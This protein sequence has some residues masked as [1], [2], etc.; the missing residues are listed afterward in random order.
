M[1][2]SGYR[3]LLYWLLLLPLSLLA[4]SLQDR[5][6]LYMVFVVFI[7][8]LFFAL[9]AMTVEYVIRKIYRSLREIIVFSKKERAIRSRDSTTESPLE[10]MLAAALDAHGVAYVREYRISNIHVDFAFPERKLAVE[11]DGHRYHASRDDKT[12]DAKRDA[13][14]KRRGWRVLRFTGDD[15][16]ND[17]QACVRKISESR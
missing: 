14:L 1:R 16:R 17:I 5:G 2:L 10:R 8:V 13:F 4:L 7:T 12:R 9:A 3:L 11:C 6:V 15:I